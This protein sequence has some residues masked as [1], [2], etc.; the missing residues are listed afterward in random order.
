MLEEISS[1]RL[2]NAETSDETM[3]IEQNI[4]VAAQQSQQCEQLSGEEVID[5]TLLD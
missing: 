5:P 3:M 4:R 1:F 2:Q